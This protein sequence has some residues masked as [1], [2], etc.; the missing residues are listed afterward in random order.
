MAEFA[1]ELRCE[2]LD[3]V[4]RPHGTEFEH[5]ILAS[6]AEIFRRPVVVECQFQ[7]VVK[8]ATTNAGPNLNIAELAIGIKGARL[9]DVKSGNVEAPFALGRGKTKV[10]VEFDAGEVL[11][12]RTGTEIHVGRQCPRNKSPCTDGRLRRLEWL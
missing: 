2:I 10:I 3:L 7:L 6:L 9:G 11:S 1:A 4:E 5:I 12:A 8:E